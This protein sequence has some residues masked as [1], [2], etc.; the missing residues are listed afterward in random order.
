MTSALLGLLLIAWFTPAT[1]AGESEQEFLQGKSKTC[2]SCALE[3]RRSSGGTWQ[4]R[5]CQALD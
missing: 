1:W 5:I 2:R 3:T 4:A